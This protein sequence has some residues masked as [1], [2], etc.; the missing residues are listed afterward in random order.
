[1]RASQ[2]TPAMAVSENKPNAC[3]TG[4]AGQHLL[5]FLACAKVP[6][7]PCILHVPLV[8]ESQVYVV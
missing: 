1:M 5:I 8:L 3:G 2:R 6:T 7:A 4:P